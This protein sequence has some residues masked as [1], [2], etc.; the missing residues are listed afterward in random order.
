MEF[1]TFSIKEV[2][3]KIS[4][5]NIQNIDKLF[6]TINNDATKLLNIKVIN[7][8]HIG[9]SEE[10]ANA[11]MAA[12]ELTK[13]INKSESIKLKKITRSSDVY[14][15]LKPFN[16]HLPHEEFYYVL[17]NRRNGVL[18]F[19]KLSQGGLAGTVVDIRLIL[20][21][22]LEYQASSIILCHNHPSGN[23]QPSDADIKITKKIREGSKL[24]DIEVLDHIIIGDGYSSMADDMV[25]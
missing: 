21:A 8:L 17:L 23:T 24:L 13:R 1:T 19:K 15:L 9:F 6:D 12:I 10:E 16:D 3:Y 18:A 4:K 22:A 14:D 20:K 5:T 25:I 7:L 11:L 2:L